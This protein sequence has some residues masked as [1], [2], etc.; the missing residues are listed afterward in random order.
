MRNISA[1]NTMHTKQGACLLMIAIEK[2]VISDGITS[3]N[4]TQHHF[5]S[6]GRLP[7]WFENV[8]DQRLLDGQK[9]RELILQL[10]LVELIVAPRCHYDLCLLFQIEVFPREAWVDVV[11]V[12]LEYLIVAHHTRICEIPYSSEVSLRHFD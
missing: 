7:I 6:L 12:H 2:N 1:S 10:S 8:F 9:L 4:I 11:S 3:T 5:S